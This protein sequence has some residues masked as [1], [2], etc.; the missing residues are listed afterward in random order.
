MKKGLNLLF[1]GA[2]IAVLSQNASAYDFTDKI[3]GKASVKIGYNFKHHIGSYMNTYL[4]GWAKMQDETSAHRIVH[5][6]SAQHYITLGVGYDFYRGCKTF[7][8]LFD[9]AQHRTRF[10]L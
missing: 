3:Y 1:V 4:K 5:T 2:L 8:Q 10:T 7:Y 9:R 6:R